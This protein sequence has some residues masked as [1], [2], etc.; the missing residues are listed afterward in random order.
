[1]DEIRKIAA[2]IYVGSTP[3]IELN[4]IN[5]LVR[6]ISPKGKGSRIFLKDEVDNPT[7]SFKNRRAFLPVYEA[8]KSGYTGKMVGVS[9]A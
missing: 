4:N 3:L 2:E 7:G 6:S 9:I 1:M 5:R 8:K